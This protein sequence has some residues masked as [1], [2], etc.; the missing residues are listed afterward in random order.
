[1]QFH[2]HC[3]KE[4]IGHLEIIPNMDYEVFSFVIW[5]GQLKAQIRNNSF[6]DDPG[7]LQ[8]FCL[9]TSLNNVPIY[10]EI[11]VTT[12]MQMPYTEIDHLF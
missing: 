11:A 12:M 3:I 9:R 7:K 8:L 10:Y 4:Q 6:A 5:I 2:E 1:M